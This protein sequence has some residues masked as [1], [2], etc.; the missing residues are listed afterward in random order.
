MTR[1]LL[2]ATLVVSANA[3][4][5]DQRLE[6][7]AYP[8]VVQANG[9]FVAQVGSTAQLSLQIQQG[10][11]VIV[12]GG[13]NWFVSESVITRE[14]AT[15]SRL[16]VQPA[17]SSLWA[18]GVLAGFEVVPVE[19]HFGTVAGVV[20][21][22]SFFLKGGAGVGSTR[23]RLAAPGTAGEGFALGPVYGDT[24]TRLTALVGAGVRLEFGRLALRLEVRELAYAMQV[25]TVN[26]CTGSELEAIAAAQR[27]PRPRSEVA[28]S[29]GCRPEAFVTPS[30]APVA[31]AL[32][33]ERSSD[34]VNNLGLYL[35]LAFFL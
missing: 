19:G 32:A 30:S 3:G 28:V 35:G 9:K 29:R 15:N 4:A 16:G 2:G 27:G 10:F 24:G 13:V 18:W 7:V 33:K 5:A 17:A 11:A 25:D 34:M 20:G 14:F 23:V 22:V 31:A 8:A 26:G 6:L 21:T 12:T 1:L